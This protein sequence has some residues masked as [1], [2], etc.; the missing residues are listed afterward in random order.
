MEIEAVP[1]QQDLMHYWREMFQ[2]AR[3]HFVTSP[4]DDE[5]QDHLLR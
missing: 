4:Y 2:C 5:P 1:L 3:I